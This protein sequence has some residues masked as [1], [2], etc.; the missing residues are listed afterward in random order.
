MKRTFVFFSVI[1]VMATVF[2][3]CSG[4]AP[5]TATSAPAPSAAATAAPAAV[6]T[7]AP[8][9]AAPVAV[10]TGPAA[11][12]A[13]AEPTKAVTADLPALK[14]GALQ[15]YVAHIEFREEAVGAGAAQATPQAPGGVEMRYNSEPTPGAYA[16]TMTGSGTPGSTAQSF[17][18]VQSGAD[19]YMFVAEQNKWVK[20][21]AG[22]SQQLPAMG[23]VLDPNKLAQDAPSGLFA[24]ANVVN[25]HEDVDGV[26]TTHYRATAAQA[27]ELIKDT[28]DQSRTADSGTADFWV[29]NANGYLKQYLLTVNLKDPTGQE[30]RQT[31]KMTLSDENK[32][33]AIATPAPDQVISM[34]DFQQG[35][36]TAMVARGT[37]T[38][39]AVNDLL[40][41]LA[42]P[43]QGKAITTADLPAAVD[44][45]ARNT[46]ADINQAAL[47]ES[48]ADIPTLRK[49]YH[50]QLTA[51]GW[52]QTEDN[53]SSDPLM[54]DQVSYGKGSATLT[55]YI[56]QNPAAKQNFILV[57]AES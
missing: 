54:P 28:G 57:V 33:V 43:P 17:Q 14:L 12:E 40:K 19:T 24:K 38:R 56:L 47:F 48:S 7:V 11:A 42:V 6:P 5:A 22:S 50:D 31:I 30:Y 35:M 18:M 45:L 9:T 55:V 8:A 34:G 2:A 13:T 15:S 39:S 21:P 27:K 52:Q 20:M 53:P 29:A 46:V 16:W 23:D 49:F 10:A 37:A 25:G 3:G 51:Q 41:T 32:P 36:A 44:A 26:D 4:Q 1:V